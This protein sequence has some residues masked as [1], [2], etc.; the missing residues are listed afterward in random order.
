MLFSQAPNP[1]LTPTLWTRR[2]QVLTAICSVIFTIG[3]ALQNF[4]IVNQDML[5]HSM[6]LSGMTPAEAADNAP[7]FLL[8]FRIVGTLFIIGNALGI[9]ALSGRTWVFW[10]ILVVNFIQATGVVAIP[11]EVWEATMDK[12]GW[13]GML[14]SIVTDGGALILVIVLVVSF[15]R[16]RTP[17]AQ[18]RTEE[19]AT[20]ATGA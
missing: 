7:G 12:Y 10:L 4:V 19:V 3:T 16:Y 1:G 18:R 13:I 6:Q 11:P 8:G 17:W 15:I 20:D 2:L 5:E 14:P 9:L